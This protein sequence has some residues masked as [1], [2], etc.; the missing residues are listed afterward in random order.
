M[1][2][3]SGREWVLSL[4]GRDLAAQRWHDG[5]QGPNTPIAEQAPD[6]CD[7]CGFLI[8][9]AGPLSDTFGVC[10]NGMANDDGKVV[11]LTHGCGAHSG[12]KLSR[13]AAPQQLPPPVFDTVNVD[14][15]DS[16]SR[17]RPSSGARAACAGRCG[18]GGS[19]R[20]R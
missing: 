18:G 9:L 17:F 10:A 8:S 3:G 20:C 16:S 2:S 19:T 11:A 1:R 14:E 12:A 6:S 5:E 13:S 7:S 4:E 15:V